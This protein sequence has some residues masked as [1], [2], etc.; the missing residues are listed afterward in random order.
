LEGDRRTE[1]RGSELGPRGE[2]DMLVDWI[3]YSS[4]GK[5]DLDLTKK[6]GES[7]SLSR[8][9][10]PICGSSSFTEGLEKVLKSLGEARYNTQEKFALPENRLF[11]GRQSC[12]KKVFTVPKDLSTS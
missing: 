5:T 8:I 6:G 7:Q 1:E 10:V 4:R 3:Y 2:T 9:A 12:N 11:S